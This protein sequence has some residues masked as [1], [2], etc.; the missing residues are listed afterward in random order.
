VPMVDLFLNIQLWFAIH[1]F[2]LLDRRSVEINSIVR[3][4]VIFS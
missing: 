4:T 1:D 2:H 3:S